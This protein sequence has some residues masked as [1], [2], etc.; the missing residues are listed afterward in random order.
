MT[1]AIS[2]SQ[3]YSTTVC[4]PATDPTCPPSGFRTTATTIT[5]HKTSNTAFGG[6]GSP[7]ANNSG[8][9][10]ENPPSGTGTP[11]GGGT[12]AG[13]TRFIQDGTIG[14]WH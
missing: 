10:T 1:D 8:C 6:Y 11:S 2:T 9:S 13:D 7:L 12:C 4:D 5:T 3:S 14:F